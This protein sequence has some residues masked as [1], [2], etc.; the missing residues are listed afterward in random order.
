LGGRLALQKRP[1][2]L[3]KEEGYLKFIDEVFVIK[4]ETYWG[5]LFF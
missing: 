1:S 3:S 2:K 5:S 4:S